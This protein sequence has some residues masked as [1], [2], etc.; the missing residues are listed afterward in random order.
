MRCTGEREEVVRPSGRG[1]D[2]GGPL[3]F[4]VAPSSE[5]WMAA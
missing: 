2:A 4:R 1:H 5:E 3:L